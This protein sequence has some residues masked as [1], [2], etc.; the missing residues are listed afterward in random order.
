[1]ISFEVHSWWWRTSFGIWHLALTHYFFGHW[2][3]E[4]FHTNSTHTVHRSFLNFLISHLHGLYSIDWFV[5][6]HHIKI[7]INKSSNQRIN[8][9]TYQHQRIQKWEKEKQK[10]R[11]QRKQKSR[12]PTMDP[13]S[14]Y[15]ASTASAPC[16]PICPR[17]LSPAILGRQWDAHR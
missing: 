3:F 14:N 10:H 9:S 5:T 12:I 16:L 6:I 13:R 2:I 11:H 15:A 1:M 17:Q 8:I 7:N 4:D